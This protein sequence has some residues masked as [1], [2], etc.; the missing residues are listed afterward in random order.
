MLAEASLFSPW[1]PLVLGIMLVASSV[2]F[3]V[4]CR[5]WTVE[6]TWMS[7]EEWASANGF[8][9]YG[10]EYASRPEGLAVF[11]GVEQRVLMSLEDDEISIVQVQTPLPPPGPGGRTIRW[12]LLVRKLE[13]SWPTA[14][15]RPVS[16][17]ISVADYLPLNNMYGT[18][19]GERFASYGQTRWITRGL[20]ESLVRGLLPPDIALVLMGQYIVL[21]FSTRP[22][23]ALTF[24]RME[25]LVRQVVGHLPRR[26]GGA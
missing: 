16:R 18:L 8:H 17:S 24:E 4:L 22:F 21:D 19:P 15:L 23:D 10:H 1:V 6:R 25:S 3:W 14:A 20:G 26:E 9:L 7:L 5:Q 13:S 2:V 11:G 12:N